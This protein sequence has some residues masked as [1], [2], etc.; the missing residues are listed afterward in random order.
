MVGRLQIKGKK[1]ITL[2]LCG[3]AKQRYTFSSLKVFNYMGTR[4]KSL[5]ARLTARVKNA[6]V[7]RSIIA[8]AVERSLFCMVNTVLC[9]S[10][11]EAVCQ[12]INRWQAT[13][14][15]GANS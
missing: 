4:I 1:I 10:E 7:R 14:G 3:S 12:G 11:G 8:M 13:T 9:F 2:E 15:L 6:R 5:L